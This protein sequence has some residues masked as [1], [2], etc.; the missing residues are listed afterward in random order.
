MYPTDETE[1]INIIKSIN[2]CKVSGPHSIPSDILKLLKENIDKSLQKLS[3]TPLEKVNTLYLCT[4]RLKYNFDYR[5]YPSEIFSILKSMDHGL[6]F[7]GISKI[8]CHAVF[9]CCHV[10]TWSRNLIGKKIV[11]PKGVRLYT[12]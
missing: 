9:P 3:I 5:K 1:I 10:V 12:V 11:S 4:L 7:F 2:V 8:S 6:T